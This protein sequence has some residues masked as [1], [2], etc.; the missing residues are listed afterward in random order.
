MEFEVVRE[1]KPPKILVSYFYFKN[2]PLKKFVEQIGYKPEIMLDSGAYSA[3][4][5]GRNISPLDYM[6][7]IRRNE[8]YISRYIMLDV[9][10]DPDLSLMYYRIMRMKGFNPIPVYHYGTSEKYLQKYIRLGERYIAIGGTVPET[11]K[12]RV[13]GWVSYLIEKYKGISFHLLGSSSQKIIS[14]PGLCSCD[15]SSWITMAIN[16]YPEH[17][18]G[19]SRE[20][21]VMRAKWQM[22]YMMRLKKEPYELQ[23]GFI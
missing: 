9:I 12:E 16:G 7:Y 2:R 1:I 4:S 5:T 22:G 19:K 8:E 3:W 21:K 14:V 13:A 18:P 15:S 6:Q 10:G 20:S 17:I 23:M 11:N